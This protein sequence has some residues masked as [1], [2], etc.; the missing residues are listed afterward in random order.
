[1]N[2]A[3][4]VLCGGRPVMGVPTAI[5]AGEAG[6]VERPGGHLGRLR[7]SLAVSRL[8]HPIV[9]LLTLLPYANSGF[10]GPICYAA[11]LDTLGH[12]ARAKL[13]VTV[14]HSDPAQTR[15]TKH[16]VNMVKSVTAEEVKGRSHARASQTAGFMRYAARPLLWNPTGPGSANNHPAS[17]RALQAVWMT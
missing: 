17:I 3:R 6:G 4:T 7:T 10:E 16:T 8:F 2:R 5:C 13:S 15:S 12:R 9:T 1:V 11:I 14:L